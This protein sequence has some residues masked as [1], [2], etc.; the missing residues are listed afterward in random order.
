VFADRI[1]GD[2][3]KWKPAPKKGCFFGNHESGEFYESFLGCCFSFLTA[4]K[5]EMRE[6]R[7]G[8]K[9]HF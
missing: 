4:K 9:F 5:D 1:E 2:E 8:L 6:R 7:H 3:K